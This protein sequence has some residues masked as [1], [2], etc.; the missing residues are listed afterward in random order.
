MQTESC[1]LNVL[2]NSEQ[3]FCGI[4]IV[5]GATRVVFEIIFKEESYLIFNQGRLA[6]MFIQIVLVCACVC[7]CARVCLCVCG[8][9]CV[10]M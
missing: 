2:Q 1:T 5:C 8:C 7:V 6:C 10:C 4:F 3:K 9:E